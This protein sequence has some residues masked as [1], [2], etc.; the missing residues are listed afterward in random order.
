MFINISSRSRM[1]V[2][3]SSLHRL[4][5]LMGESFDEHWK[6]FIKTPVPDYIKTL[7]KS[8]PGRK[9]PSAVLISK[10]IDSHES[11]RGSDDLVMSMSFC[12]TVHY[13]FLL[14]QNIPLYHLLIDTDESESFASGCTL[15]KTQFSISHSSLVIPHRMFTTELEAVP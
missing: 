11:M 6:T 8:E 13:S 12:P 9:F 1:C 4:R 10:G 15:F 7:G 5:E 2:A 3:I 14:F